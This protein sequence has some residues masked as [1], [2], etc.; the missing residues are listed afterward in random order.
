MLKGLGGTPTRKSVMEL[1]DVK[2]AR[3]RP[4]SMPNALTFDAVYD[5]GIKD[6]HFTFG[7]K[8]PEANEYHT[9]MASELQKCLSGS[10]SPEET[11]KSLQSQLDD[12]NDA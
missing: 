4:T 12:L 3:Q 9:I 7:P 11:C 2:A 5:Y 6:P 10:Q 8:I 1:P